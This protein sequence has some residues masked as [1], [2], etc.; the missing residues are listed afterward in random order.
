M[1]ANEDIKLEWVD[2]Y[3]PTTLEDYVLNEGLKQYFR[4]MIKNKSL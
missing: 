1:N 2:K 4:D 3:R